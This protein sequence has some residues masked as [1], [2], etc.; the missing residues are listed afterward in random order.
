MQSKKMGMWISPN[1]KGLKGE[2]M[3][4]QIRDRKSISE[5]IRIQKECV[6]ANFG[7]RLDA[8]YIVVDSLFYQ[9]DIILW[10]FFLDGSQDVALLGSAVHKSC[11]S[12]LSCIELERKGLYGSSRILMRH[13]F[14]YLMIGKFYSV[15]KNKELLNRWIEGIGYPMRK[16][17]KNINKPGTEEMSR[18]WGVLCN[19]THATIYSQQITLDSESTQKEHDINCNLIGALVEMTFHLLNMHLINPKMKSY[20]ESVEGAHDEMIL[21]N[22]LK[23]EQNRLLKLSRKNMT[24]ATK[25]LIK[26]YRASW[27]VSDNIIG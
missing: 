16:I 27:E 26:E 22:D 10:T 9:F 17:F 13:A 21:I 14:E 12:L 8:S 7:D 25:S 23:A 3:R 6:Q 20:I 1:L 19:F 2:F 24:K 4:D 18:L 15:S 5:Q 11:M